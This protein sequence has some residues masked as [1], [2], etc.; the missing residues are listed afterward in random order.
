[1]DDL[2]MRSTISSNV[3]A[4]DVPHTFPNPCLIGCVISIDESGKV[5]VDKTVKLEIHL[6]WTTFL[7][8][9]VTSYR[10]LQRL[11]HLQSGSVSPETIFKTAVAR[12]RAFTRNVTL[13]IKHCMPA[14]VK[15]SENGQSPR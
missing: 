8:R 6:F 7:I 10:Q 2:E 12:L 13:I 5:G 4:F 11:V 9:T 1:M 15:I 3:Q 14:W